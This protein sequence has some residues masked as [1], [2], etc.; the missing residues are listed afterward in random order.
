MQW[1]DE[2]GALE[3]SMRHIAD[4]KRRP[5]P[6]APFRAGEADVDALT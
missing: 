2:V 4:K 1:L 6:Q 3:E 5:T